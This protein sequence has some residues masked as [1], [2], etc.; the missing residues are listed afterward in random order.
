MSTDALPSNDD[1]GP[2]PLGPLPRLD[3]LQVKLDTRLARD[4]SGP[5]IRALLAWLTDPIGLDLAIGR[6]EVMA[7][8]AGLGRPG[9]IAQ[10]TW[11]RLGTRVGLGLETPLAHALVDR[12][13]GHDRPSGEE[14]L[15]VTPV[16]WGILTFA[17]ARTLTQLSGRPGPLG[18][19]DLVLDRVGPEPF[20][21]EG[22]GP[23]LTV[24]WPIGV[25]DLSGSARLWLPATL[26]V[27]WLDAA[28]PTRPTLDPPDLAGPLG[29]LFGEWR[30]EAGTIPL[31]R[32]LGRLRVGR[33]MALPLGGTVES[34]TGVVTLRLRDDST[35]YTLP[36]D[37]LPQS[38]GGRLAVRPP[39]RREPLPRE[40][41][42][43]SP[44]AE[45]VASASE[46]PATL[47]V[48]LGRA[49]VS[50]ARLASLRPGDVLELTRD[51][52]E[53]VELTSGGRLV[54]RGELVQIDDSL[55]VRVL[56][57]F[58]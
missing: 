46:V 29:E 31:R 43:V 42:A 53:P 56:R 13:L 19:W 20:A 32:G 36:A 30:A 33:V 58:L 6:P 5:A 12:L 27:A 48:E 55:G 49:T 3:A 47:V 11:P 10:M 26:A 18:E 40:I 4:E 8:A 37:P 9:V 22:L 34:P 1:A 38:G 50:L 24:R 28:P 51:P 44:P 2:G 14:R 25:G 15:Q 17:L 45:P 57:V 16:E 35:L 52:S 7:R 54:A 23:L 39:I 41:P 21:A